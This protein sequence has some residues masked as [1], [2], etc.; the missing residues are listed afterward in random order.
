MIRKRKERSKGKNEV[1]EGQET[2]GHKKDKM[3]VILVR[4]EPQRDKTEERE[5][6]IEKN[7]QEVAGLK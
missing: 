2:R 1:K 3:R 5:R 7:T 6:E 4:A